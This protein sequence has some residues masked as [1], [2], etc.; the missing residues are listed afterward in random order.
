MGGRDHAGIVS[1]HEGRFPYPLTSTETQLD[2]S[3]VYEA[4]FG[5]VPP[6]LSKIVIVPRSHRNGV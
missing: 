5:A 1:A 2:F 6:R 3:G 4:P